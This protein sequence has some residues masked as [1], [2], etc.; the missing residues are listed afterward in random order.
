ML[1]LL[2]WIKVLT[3]LQGE[4]RLLLFIIRSQYL[5]SRPF[6]L[7]SW[8]W[9]RNFVYLESS[10]ARVGGITT[11]PSTKIKNN[12]PGLIAISSNRDSKAGQLSSDWE[13][14]QLRAPG[15]RVLRCEARGSSQ[16]GNIQCS[17]DGVGRTYLRIF[18]LA[19]TC[20]PRPLI[21]GKQGV[22]HLS[23]EHAWVKY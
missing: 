15:D 1:L 3:S 6:G 16:A 4:V 10:W 13:C 11:R 5:S 7:A 18:T 9:V 2:P 23:P 12:G 22:I 8:C 17:C 19:A 14:V 20:K 21:M